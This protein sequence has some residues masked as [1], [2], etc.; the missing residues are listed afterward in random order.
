METFH[1]AL[2]PGG[3]LFLGSS[4]SIDGS[5]DLYLTVSKRHNVFQS[6]QASRRAV[7]MTENSVPS[8]FGLKS[9]LQFDD[10]LEKMPHRQKAR[11]QE[12]LSFGDLHQRLLE[13]YAPP[14]LIVNENYEVVHL[15]EKAGSYLQVKGGDL[16]NNILD[17]IKPELR[18]ELRS[19]LYQAKREQ[20]NIELKK[21]ISA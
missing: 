10:T 13:Q 20:I 16:S 6:R 21:H 8:L 11:A 7:P 4:E 15:T 3:Y 18:L 19:A 9:P 2:N 1:F 17:L 12:R 5:S 14:S